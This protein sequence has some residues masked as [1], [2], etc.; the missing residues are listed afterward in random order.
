MTAAGEQ[1]GGKMTRKLNRTEKAAGAVY[2]T[3]ILTAAWFGVDWAA[4]AL[5]TLGFAS[6]LFAYL[7]VPRGKTTMWGRPCSDRTERYTGPDLYG[8]TYYRDHGTHGSYY[9]AR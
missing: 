7:F 4:Y 3:A 1:G 9:R 5:L 2:W 6:F 8:G